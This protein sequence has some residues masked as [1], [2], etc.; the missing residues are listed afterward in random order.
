MLEFSKNFKRTRTYKTTIRLTSESGN[1]FHPYVEAYLPKEQHIRDD[2]STKIWHNRHF[3]FENKST[4]SAEVMNGIFDAVI[5]GYHLDATFP[6]TKKHEVT[7][8]LRSYLITKGTYPFSIFTGDEFIAWF[9]VMLRA[10]RILTEDDIT[11]R[12][13]SC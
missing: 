7:I 12:T 10:E 9:I 8:S 2:F 4:T 5:K 6:I 13:S 3:D 1:T 11:E